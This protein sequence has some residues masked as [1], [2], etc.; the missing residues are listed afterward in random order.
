M[1]TPKDIEAEIRR[2]HT[3]EKWPIG[4]IARQLNVHHSVV[5][6]VLKAREGGA[7]TSASQ[8]RSKNIDPY[9]DFI[10]DTLKAYPRLPASRLYDML[11]DR[12]YLGSERTVRRESK[13]LRP[14]RHR[15]A[16]VRLTPLV[17][18]QIQVDWA[19][20]S[21]FKVDGGERG[22]WLFVALLPYSRGMFAEFVLDLS[23]DSLCRS[24]RRTGEFFG[25]HSRQWLFDNAK[26]VVLERHGSAARFHPLLVEASAHY[27]VQ[28]RLCTPR[29]ANEKGGVERSIRYLR[30]RFLAGRP[31]YSVTKGNQELLHF[32]LTIAHQRPHPTLPGRTVQEY[33]V[34]EQARLLP[35]P[36][37]PL[38]TDT[39]RPVVVDKTAFVRFDTNSYS[40][41]PEAVGKTVAI[42]A[43]DASL[44]IIDGDKEI[45]RHSRCWGRRQTRESPSHRK[46]ILDQKKAARPAKRLDHLIRIAP[47]FS[48]LVERW[49]DE[50]YNVG[51]VISRAQKLVELYGATLFEKAVE[52][53]L[54]QGTHD[55]SAIA[56]HCEQ[57]RCSAQMDVPI[58]VELG[59]HVPEHEVIPHDLEK[60]DGDA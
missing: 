19:Y 21:K 31:I 42:V 2:L 53:V 5:G 44:R 39:L 57:L 52:G 35:L 47:R 26:S 55:V 45:A 10:R 51:N 58:N 24:L 22:L 30:T 27:C 49:V 25:G 56:V 1:T 14:T 32:I 54:R 29:K 9:V 16:Y 15:E 60:Y 20:V 17:G 18:E 36:E 37:T 41:P 28:P 50:G 38:C 48:E 11:R 12:G 4:T 34:E 43:D 7:V 13:H 3:A 40:V 59:D 33:F 46:A 23:A 8:P 6:R